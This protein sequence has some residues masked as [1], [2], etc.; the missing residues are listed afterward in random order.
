MTSLADA[1]IRALRTNHDALTAVARGLG[2]DD[3]A[4]GSGAAEWSIAQVFSHLGSGAEI[5]LGSLR[6]ALDGT[7][8]PEGFNQSVWDRWNAKSPR[9]QAEDFVGASGELVAAL[10]GLDEG[11]RRDLRVRL[12]LPEPVD[13]AL[14]AGLRLSEVTL[15]RWDIEVAFDPAVTLDDEAVEVLVDLYAGP[16]ALLFGFLGKG[17]AL[18]GRRVVVRV[19]TTTPTREFGLV[20]G[21]AVGLAAEAPKPADA[22]LAAPAEA[23]LRLATGRLAPEHTPAQVVVHGDGKLTLDDLRRVFPGF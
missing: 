21:D 10:E 19:E 15:H 16:L 20:I 1:A 11:T 5:S 8:L 13:L 7:A 18:D 23:W 17:E 6:A 3:L 12:F 14:F 9:E 4:R 2:A 22:V